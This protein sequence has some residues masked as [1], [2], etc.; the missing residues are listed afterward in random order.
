MHLLRHTGVSHELRRVVVACAQQLV[1]PVVRSI[2]RPASISV[3]SAVRNVPQLPQLMQAILCFCSSERCVDRSGGQGVAGSNPVSPTV[4]SSRL[5]R[6][7]SPGQWA[8]SY[9]L[10][11]RAASPIPRSA[12]GVQERFW[13]GSCFR[14]Q[15]GSPNRSSSAASPPGPDGP[16]PG[17]PRP[18]HRSARRARDHSRQPGAVVGH[19]AGTHPAQRVLH[20]TGAGPA[21]EARPDRCGPGARARA[22]GRQWVPHPEPAVPRADDGADPGRVLCVPGHARTA[23]PPSRPDREGGCRRAARRG[24][25]RASRHR[26]RPRRADRGGRGRASGPPARARGPDA[27]RGA[28]ATWPRAWGSPARRRAPTSSGSTPRPTRPPGLRRPC[29]RCATGC[30]ARSICREN[31]RRHGGFP[32]LRSPHP[33]LTRGHAQHIGHQPEHRTGRS[34][35]GHRR[36]PGQ[37]VRDRGQAI[38]DEPATTFS[39]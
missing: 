18:R 31:T 28:P 34:G 16:A 2:A 23:F 7:G 33:I 38:G 30:S 36:V 12:R 15:M 21:R 3:R 25:G 22:P 32:R 9:F 19:R 39:Y 8:F 10:P 4:C 37:A 14:W 17:R 35:E 5:A 11:V 1:A 13:S 24:P 29:A 27:A 20:G 6:G 26:R